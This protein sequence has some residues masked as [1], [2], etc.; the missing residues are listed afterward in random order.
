MPTG[1]GKFHQRR[2]NPTK[3]MSVQSWKEP[4]R[5]AGK[6]EFF[7]F[8]VRR[9]LF[10]NVQQK[11]STEVVEIISVHHALRVTQGL[12]TRPPKHV[13]Y[14][15]IVTRF[16]NFSNTKLFSFAL[17]PFIS[18]SNR[19]K[20]RA[21]CREEREADWQ[22]RDLGSKAPNAPFNGNNKLLSQAIKSAFDSYLRAEVH[23]AI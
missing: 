18:T 3:A 16:P 9:G 12:L 19:Q 17:S 1:E 8:F 23:C 21:A 5:K 11:K 20:R 2:T 10:S 7:F 22:R 14:N 4:T 15:P 6:T 13:H